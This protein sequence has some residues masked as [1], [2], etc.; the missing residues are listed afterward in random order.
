M[1]RGEL[2]TLV[3]SWLDDPLGAYFTPP[4]VNVWLNN[5]QHEVQKQLIQAGQNFY[6]QR[7]KGL[8]IQN[9]DTYELPTDFKRDHKF[10]LVLSG[11]G[12]NEVR[13]TMT[14]VTY[15]QLDQVSQ[16]TGVPSAFC[17][18]KNA[19][20]IRPI[21]N[22]AYV[23]YLHQ[24]YRVVDMTQDTDIPDVPSDYTEYLAVIA[25]LDGLMKDQREASQFILGKKDVY[26]KMLEQDS[27]NRDVSAP[28]S[29]VVCDDAGGGYL[30]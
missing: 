24:S 20:I 12:V 8:T 11:T 9:Q 7:M 5:A 13:Q 2:R 10:E 22:N 6:V 4:Q 1:N 28:R 29:V 21:P 27:Q 15:I 3:L 26:M 25:T 19:V 16:N 18:K 30:F 23:M 14:P 17:I